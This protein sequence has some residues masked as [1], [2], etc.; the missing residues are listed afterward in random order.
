MALYSGGLT[1]GG[2]RQEVKLPREGFVTNQA[3]C[4]AKQF[5]VCRYFTSAGTSRQEKASCA[6]QNGLL[7]DLVQNSQFVEFPAQQD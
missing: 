3:A 6:V 5:I 7:A 2:F 4:S 1:R